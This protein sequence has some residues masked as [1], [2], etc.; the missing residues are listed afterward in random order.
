[1]GF[2]SD[3]KNALTFH[4]DPGRFGNVQKWMDMPG[5]PTSFMHGI[6]M[7]KWNSPY[8]SER[9]SA[10]E[11]A[12]GG[13]S[14]QPWAR[15]IG[16]SVGTF[17]TPYAGM[18]KA[19]YG[20]TQGSKSG[21]SPSNIFE[22]A[23]GLVGSGG[24]QNVMSSMLGTDPNLYNSNAKDLASQGRNGDDNLLHVSDDELNQLKSTGKLTTNP[25]TGLPEAFSFSNPFSGGGGG[26]LGSIIGGAGNLFGR[27]QNN[28]DLGGIANT[29]S[30]ASN[31]L[32]APQRQQYQQQLGNM[33]SPQGA[34][35]FMQN[36]PSVQAQRRMI[37]DQMGATFAHS[38]NLPMTSIMGSA[39]LA[40]AFGGQYNQRIQDLSTLGGFNQ[41]NPYGGMP[42]SNLMGPRQ[43]SNAMGM[44]GMGSLFGQIPGLFGQGGGGGG[45]MENL[46]N[47]PQYMSG[48]GMGFD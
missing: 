17:F 33:M 34:S 14:S 39:Q 12:G 29:A 44:S 28:Q 5:S 6:G 47:N 31:P 15:A 48:G 21:S 7:N 45:G 38:G 22:A 43:D 40:N 10:D 8:G 3:L 41:G 42:Y 1:M 32:A 9:N 4:G 46:F 20:M 36:D 26:G 13:S 25:S 18:G 19:A 37:G 2:G 35:D 27:N 16:R 23:P 11:I 30:N 24:Q